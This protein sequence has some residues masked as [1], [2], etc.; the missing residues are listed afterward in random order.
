[1]DYKA[2]YPMAPGYI[3]GTPVLRKFT[4]RLNMNAFYQLSVA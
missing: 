1:M 3:A 4:I 2:P